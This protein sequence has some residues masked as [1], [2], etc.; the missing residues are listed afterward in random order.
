MSEN[1]EETLEAL[2]QA[3]GNSELSKTLIAAVFDAN[4][5]DVAATVDRLMEMA[6]D[7][8]G[9]RP[10]EPEPPKAQPPPQTSEHEKTL[11]TL[12]AMFQGDLS[13]SVI[14]IVY[15]QNDGDVV[16]AVDTLL[17]IAHDE[18]AIEAIRNMAAHQRKQLE[19][20]M[21]SEQHRRNEERQ[22]QMLKELE[23]E[24]KELAE[25]ERRAK[26]EAEKRIREKDEEINRLRKQQEEEKK[27]RERLEEQRLALE[28]AR[29][30]AMHQLRLQQIEAERKA[31]EEREKL[32]EAEVERRLAERRKA[33][34]ERREEE[35][36]LA[37]ERQAKEDELKTK[38]LLVS[39][40]IQEQALVTLSVRY[41]QKLIA[42][43]WGVGKD[44]KPSP[45][46]WIGFYKVGQ[47]N[48]KYREYIK[49]RGEP[50]GSHNFAAPK[51]PGLY[52]F[53]Y[54]SGSGY[55]EVASSDVLHIGPK[56]NLNATYIA[57]SE[58]SA[59]NSGKIEV[60]YTLLSG[61]LT[62]S[63]WF[64][65]Y[66]AAERNNRRYIAT[67]YLTPV[68][69]GQSGKIVFDAPRAP[70]DYVV[71]FFPSRC[72]YTHVTMSNRIRIENRD[73]L[74]VETIKDERTGRIL[75]LRIT[76]EI[77]SVAPSASD[78]VAIYS[79]GAPNNSYHSYAYYD[80]TKPYVELSAPTAIDSY[81]VRFH[82]AHQS[83]YADVCRSEPFHVQNTDW[84]KAEVAG[85]LVAVS[86]DIHSQPRSP[87]DWVGIFRVGA[88]SNKYYAYKYIDTSSCALTFEVPT[89][90]GEYEARYFS[91][92]LGKYTDFR[93][94]RSFTVA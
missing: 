65:L 61:E 79:L 37:K 58:A 72:K 29:D 87:W 63:D 70:G 3:F 67:Q 25:R 55:N 51:T 52:V 41:S 28:K 81:E 13:R 39:R 22:R 33:E 62:T 14:S 18:E 69:A 44:F 4:N 16:G 27:E 50:R 43:S 88:P 92:N 35:A 66:A 73:V 53:K 23:E 83:K 42:V 11:A 15:A 94:S 86:W 89:E 54:F 57:P 90:P 78:Y 77:F 47:P 10:V 2:H 19:D 8:T 24:R 26:A 46:D 7:T 5:G 71:R 68:E 20:E 30:E 85:G 34:E 36:R 84:V 6:K 45:N 93:K 60:E 38:E 21:L 56:L 49:T 32:L 9:R 48:E 31:R 40:I 76:A 82:S 1:R 74:K 64:G 91:N 59:R 80:H 12:Q 75:K 17:N